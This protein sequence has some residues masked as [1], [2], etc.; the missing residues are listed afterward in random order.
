MC[1]LR[2]FRDSRTTLD[3]TLFLGS[4]GG[5]EVLKVS[6]NTYSSPLRAGLWTDTPSELLETCFR[7]LIRASFTRRSRTSSKTWP[8]VSNVLNLNR[9][10]LK[11]AAFASEAEHRPQ[12][13]RA[14]K[15]QL[16]ML[17]R[18]NGWTQRVGRASPSPEGGGAQRS[19]AGF[20]LA[21]IGFGC[22]WE[23]TALLDAT[24]PSLLVLGGSGSREAESD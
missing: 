21:T 24:A 16:Y 3:R 15:A 20:G 12:I 1:T 17:R 5:V 9:A 19:A 2:D 10:G 22:G 23:L 6:S 13:W 8:T 14:R 18:R 7:S 11:L 4:G